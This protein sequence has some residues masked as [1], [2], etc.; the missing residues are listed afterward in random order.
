MSQQDPQFISVEGSINLRDFGGYTT[1]DGSKVKT[2][3]LFRCGNMSEIPDHAHDDLA[4]LDIGV[5]CDLRGVEEADTA[6]TPTG[7]PFEC[8]VHIPVWPGSSTQFQEAV[9]KKKPSVDDFLAFMETVTREIIR[10]H[11]PAYTQLFGHLLAIESGFLLHCSAGKDRTGIGAAIILSI[12]GVSREDI[13]KDYLISNQSKDLIART[14]RRFSEQASD[15]KVAFNPDSEIVK[16]MAGVK[17][18][19]LHAAFEEID[20]HFDGINGYLE[21]VGITHREVDTLKARLLTG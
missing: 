8:R 15:K 4:A 18:E 21:A 17:A 14:L 16:V 5:I 12:L 7:G 6:P 13:M 11:V 3:L 19:Y 20:N 10:E 9:A 2:G 1:S